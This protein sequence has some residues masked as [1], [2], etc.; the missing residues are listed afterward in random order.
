MLPVWLLSFVNQQ[1]YQ[2]LNIYFKNRNLLLFSSLIRK[3]VKWEWQLADANAFLIYEEFHSVSDLIF[4]VA[5]STLS[6]SL[7]I[8][9]VSE[10][11]EPCDHL[12]GKPDKKIYGKVLHNFLNC[13]VSR[14]KEK[15]PHGIFNSVEKFSHESL[16]ILSGN[17]RNIFLLE[18]LSKFSFQRSKTFRNNLSMLSINIKAAHIIFLD[19]PP[20]QCVSDKFRFFVMRK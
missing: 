13:W 18:L 4:S 8:G 16:I 19:Q 7:V 2:N 17:F 3:R 14:L 12:F 15:L 1:D 9:G 5:V 6:G 20:K 10:Q 11:P